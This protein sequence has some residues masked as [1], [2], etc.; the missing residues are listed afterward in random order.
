MHILL[1]SLRLNQ[2]RTGIFLIIMTLRLKALTLRW[3]H[4]L[5]IICKTARRAILFQL[6]L[7]SGLTLFS[8]FQGFLVSGRFLALSGLIE[9]TQVGSF[10]SFSLEARMGGVGLSLVH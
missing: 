10:F 6:A 4:H 3:I 2:Y 5:A 7:D 9:S 1:I 8:Y